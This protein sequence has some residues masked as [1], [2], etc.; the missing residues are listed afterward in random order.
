MNSE[1]IAIEKNF[2]GKSKTSLFTNTERQLFEGNTLSF[3]MSFLS[4]YF[5]NPSSCDFFN[6]T[7]KKKYYIKIT[8]LTTSLMLL[9]NLY[10]HFNTSVPTCLIFFARVLTPTDIPDDLIIPCIT[11]S[12]SLG[13]GQNKCTSPD[14][15]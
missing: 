5:L 2:S 12:L 7:G 8:N 6:S 9:I 1:F 10:L 4:T 15:C 14:C 3:C 13:L 11:L